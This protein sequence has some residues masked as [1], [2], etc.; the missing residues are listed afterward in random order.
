MRVL[1]GEEEEGKGDK[2]RRGE[3]E[4]GRVKGEGGK[5]GRGGGGGI[6]CNG[7]RRK[8]VKTCPRRAG[9]ND[10]TCW[11]SLMSAGE[12]VARGA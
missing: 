5:R 6:G 1:E 9:G 7:C 4:G 10:A 12:F 8:Q 11:I 3:S 2:S